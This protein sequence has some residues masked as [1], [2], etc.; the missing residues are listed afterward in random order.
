[1]NMIAQTFTPATESPVDVVRQIPR[2]VTGFRTTIET[3][4]DIEDIRASLEGMAENSAFRLVALEACATDDGAEGRMMRAEFAL[5]AARGCVGDPQIFAL[6]RDI[7]S[8]HR[9]NGMEKRLSR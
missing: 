9:W 8:R 6:L 4:M 3:A 5:R 7:A 2:V 1:M